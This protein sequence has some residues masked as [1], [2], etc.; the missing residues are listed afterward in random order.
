[1]SPGSS[2]CTVV[3][4][5]AKIITPDPLFIQGSSLTVFFHSQIVL[6]F[7][8]RTHVFVSIEQRRESEENFVIQQ[9]IIR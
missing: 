8:R 4:D 9:Q 6:G 5:K 3:Q 7:P 2:R 1:M